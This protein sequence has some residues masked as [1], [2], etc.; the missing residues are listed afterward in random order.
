[1][2]FCNLMESFKSRS[3]SFG[4]L[5]LSP[6]GNVRDGDHRLH[7]PP[8]RQSF[9]RFLF[10]GR[11]GHLSIRLGPDFVGSNCRRPGGPLEK[12]TSSVDGNYYLFDHRGY[13][14]LR[15]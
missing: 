8:V 15:S 13:C 4:H 3:T 14:R 2:G 5:Q 10:R 7:T 6:L 12:E 1:M 9:R 11:V